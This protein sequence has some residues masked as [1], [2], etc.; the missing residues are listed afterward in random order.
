VINNNLNEYLIFQLSIMSRGQRN[1]KGEK[2]GVNLDD[3]SNLENGTGSRKELQA[4][5]IICFM[6]S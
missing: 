2:K 1:Q 5:K 6:F 3:Y 4:E